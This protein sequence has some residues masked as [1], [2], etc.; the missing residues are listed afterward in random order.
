MFDRIEFEPRPHIS[1]DRGSGVRVRINGA[2]LTELAREIEAP[3]AVAEGSPSIAGAYS[4]LPPSPDVGP[5][6]L[7]FLGTPSWPIYRYG[8]KVEVL[9]CE[10]GEPGCWPLVCRIE[11]SA[12]TVVWKD[13]EQPHRSRDGGRPEW[14]YE[15][16]GP[17]TFG[18]GD[19]EVALAVLEGTP[20]RVVGLE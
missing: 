2:E 9:Q 1:G 16:L 4:G 8:A 15:G 10:C 18:R 17:F 20:G 14:T 13:F 11:V 7:H 3:F 6:S 12:D 5:P 19:Y